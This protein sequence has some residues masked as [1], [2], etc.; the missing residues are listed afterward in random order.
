I[1]SV[2]SGGAAA[3][4]DSRMLGALAV[5][6]KGQ[7]GSMYSETLHGAA[8]PWVVSVL[9]ALAGCIGR[10][11]GKHVYVPLA[12]ALEAC[13]RKSPAQLQLGKG[14]KVPEGTADEELRRQRWAQRHA[15]VVART[16]YGILHGSVASELATSW[17]AADGDPDS[18]EC[19]LRLAT[20]A[21]RYGFQAGFSAPAAAGAMPPYLDGAMDAATGAAGSSLQG[22]PTTSAAGVAAVALRLAAASS[23]CNHRHVAAAALACTC[24]VLEAAC[25]KPLQSVAKETENADLRPP[26]VAAAKP[27]WSNVGDGNGSS[28]MSVRS[29]LLAV[30]MQLG[31]LITAGLL[32]ALLS[33]S[34]LPRLQRVTTAMT[35]L[36]TATAHYYRLEHHQGGSAAPLHPAGLI[37][38]SLAVEAC[39]RV[40]SSWMLAAAGFLQ[41]PAQEVAALATPLAPVLAEV[42]VCA[43]AAGA[44]AW[45]AAVLEAGAASCANGASSARGLNRK[46]KRLLREFVESRVRA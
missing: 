33:S 30:V 31:P 35:L 10:P 17:R 8:D 7:V 15:T 34:P 40:L 25:D 1:R 32:A 19:V 46:L 13:M 39:G 41:V 18:A 45:E 38:P 26:V 29:E 14:S 12:V 3:G 6:E 43:G 28:G 21:V 11:G 4:G 23:G 42:G 22:S 37:S 9:E 36:A 27:P 2:R 44:G 24:A 20:A 16:L 5:G